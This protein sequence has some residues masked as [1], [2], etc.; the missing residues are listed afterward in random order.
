MWRLVRRLAERRV[1]LIAVDDLQWV[2]RP[3]LE[4]LLYLA[5]RLEELR[6]VIVSTRTSGEA[7]PTPTWRIGSRRCRWLVWSGCR[8]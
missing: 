7:G 6:V 1:A 2:D 3:S 8:R 4:L 5:R